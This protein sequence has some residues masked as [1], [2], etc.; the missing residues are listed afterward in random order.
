M[1]RARARARPSTGRTPQRRRPPALLGAQGR[2]ARSARSISW[3]VVRGV[4]D[5]L[6]VDAGRERADLPARPVRSPGARSRPTR[7]RRSSRGQ[8]GGL[9]L[10][11]QAGGA[12][13]GCLAG[14]LPR[15]IDVA[16]REERGS[17]SPRL[18]NS[19]SRARGAACCRKSSAAASCA[20][21]LSADA[22]AA[23]SSAATSSSG[24]VVQSAKWRARSSGSDTTSA[25]RLCSCRRRSADAEP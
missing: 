17:P 21:R 4:V 18:V 7:S 15:A 10:G 14:D 22:A 8:R 25:R 9:L 6:E 12:G 11:A 23:S 13:T 5:Q 3:W 16:R 20:P 1:H 2:E 24:S 19:S